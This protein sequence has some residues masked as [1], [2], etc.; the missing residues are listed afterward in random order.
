M[1]DTLTPSKRSAVMAAVKSTDTAPEL[2]VRRLLH[3]MG[4]RFRIHR[5]DLPGKPDIVLPRHKKIIFVH[6]CFWHGHAGCS[7]LRM[8][9]S[10]TDYWVNK[11][12]GNVDR[13]S[14]HIKQLTEAGWI[15]LV[16]WECELESTARVEKILAQ[17]MRGRPTHT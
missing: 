14:K 3:K 15:V 4:F 8:P 5:K 7:K 12:R 10:N 13:N 16:I 6:G 11:I 1:V 17:F 9:A 2:F